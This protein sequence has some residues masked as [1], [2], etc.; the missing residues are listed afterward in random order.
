MQGI[1][2]REATMQSVG[3]A[4]S[5]Q[6]PRRRH[7]QPR[8]RYKEASDDDD[9]ADSEDGDTTSRRGY[10]EAGRDDAVVHGSRSGL[11]G[12]R[13]PA[14]AAELDDHHRRRQLRHAPA[15]HTAMPSLQPG[16]QSTRAAP[17]G[18]TLPSF[19]QNRTAGAAHVASATAGAQT[20][21]HAANAPPTASFA[22]AAASHARM[23]VDKAKQEEQTAQSQLAD[24]EEKFSSQDL[25]EEMQ[26][27][28]EPYL[29]DIWQ[30][31]VK[32]QV[33]V[34]V[35]EEWAAFWAKAS[36]EGQ[37]PEASV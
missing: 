28:L 18:S 11:A 37:L 21:A 30:A 12:S 27:I 16:P 3:A 36:E 26:Q 7:T 6:Y 31:H 35:Q 19:G 25:L 4:G 32:A 24:W 22:A 23:L 9:F 13:R 15:H 5:R 2:A 14:A 10:V 1:E 33:T 20:A 17:F 29:Q 8:P 34:A